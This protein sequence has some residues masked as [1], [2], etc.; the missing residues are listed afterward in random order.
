MER[1]EDEKDGRFTVDE[2]LESGGFFQVS[3]EHDGGVALGRLGKGMS[4]GLV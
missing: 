1:A 2:T 4:R 3:F